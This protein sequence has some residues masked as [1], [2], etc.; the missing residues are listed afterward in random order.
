MV[1]NALDM[2]LDD[3]I[4][5]LKRIK[6]RFGRNLEYQNLRKSLPKDWPM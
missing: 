3:L 2:D 6:E 5:R 4:D 1:S